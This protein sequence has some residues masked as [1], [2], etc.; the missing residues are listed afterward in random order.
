MKALK[1][2][3]TKYPCIDIMRRVLQITAFKLGYSW[4]NGTKDIDTDEGIYYLFLEEIGDMCYS[5][6]LSEYIQ[7]P[8]T[9]TDAL[10]FLGIKP[11]S[12]WDGF[13]FDLGESGNPELSKQLQEFLFSVGS[14][15]NSGDSE[16]WDTDTRFLQVWADNNILTCGSKSYKVGHF[17][18]VD[19]HE[20]LGIV[21]PPYGI[22]TFK[23]DGKEVGRLHN[24]GTY[25]KTEKITDTEYTGM[26]VNKVSGIP[27]VDSVLTID[28]WDGSFPV[29]E[30]LIDTIQTSLSYPG[31]LM[32]QWPDI[33]ID[34]QIGS[35]GGWVHAKK[36]NNIN[37]IS[38][39]VID[40]R[41]TIYDECKYVESPELTAEE[42]EIKRASDAMPDC[43][44][45]D[46]KS[47]NITIDF[48]T[49]E[50]KTKAEEINDHTTPV[51]LDQLWYPQYDKVFNMK[52]GGRGG[53]KLLKLMT[54]TNETEDHSRA[55]YAAAEAVG[56]WDSPTGVRY[57]MEGVFICCQCA[58]PVMDNIAFDTDENCYC[59]DCC[60]GKSIVEVLISHDNNVGK[61][62]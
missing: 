48:E 38:L 41:L 56:Y 13:E 3:L 44:V 9:P 5:N 19:P 18:P 21:K 16:V 51:N 62:K 23:T 54:D 28:D 24:N 40:N 27:M 25:S 37:V 53:T 31:A 52:T 32:K 34:F 43:M 29:P 7:S 58:T 11:G 2:D 47:T 15:W 30:E 45:G 60:T 61:L 49:L 4:D 12:E 35:N 10:E 55:I 59:G 46:V 50:L 36:N 33:D 1:F 20:F 8:E 57:I 6:Q 39:Q 22:I 42:R 14:K 17:I 26:W